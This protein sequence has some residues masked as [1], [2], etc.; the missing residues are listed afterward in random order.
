M[1][2]ILVVD[3]SIF[4]VNLIKTRL[5][6]LG[7]EV[8][9]ASDGEEAL[10]SIKAFEPDLMLLDLMLPKISGMEVLRRVSEDSLNVIVVSSKNREHDKFSSLQLGAK[11]FVTKPF[12]LE[13]LE[14]KIKKLC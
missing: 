6:H 11:A 10:H 3:D 8:K 2:K 7:Y 14:E 5:E 4:M 13:D 1:K 12:E 9:S